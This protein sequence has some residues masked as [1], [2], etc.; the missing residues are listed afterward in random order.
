VVLCFLQVVLVL[1][2]LLVFA[3]EEN[4]VEQVAAFKAGRHGNLTVFLVGVESV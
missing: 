2:E 1:F 3:A 4:E